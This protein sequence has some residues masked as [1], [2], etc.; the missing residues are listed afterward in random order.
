MGFDHVFDTNFTADLTIIEEGT[1]LILRLYK[2]LVQGDTSVALPQFTSCSPG[3]VKYCEHFYPEY[4]PNL[5]TAKSPQQM[6]GALIKTFYAEKMGVDPKPTSSAW[7]SCR[8]RP[9]SSSATARRCAP[10]ATRTWT[11]ASPPASWGRCSGRPVWT[12]PACP[13]RTS[14]TRSATA[15]G[16][17]LIFGA[18]G[19]VMESALR[20]VLELVTGKKV[21]TIY[22]HGD[23]MP[24]RGFEGVRY[25]ELKISEVG[26][27]PELLAHLVPDWDWLK[28]ATLK[29]AVAH[30]TANAHK[31]M[32]DI[33]AGGK[34]SECHFIEF[35]ACPGGCLGGG[36]QPIPTNKEIRAARAR[37]HLRRRPTDLD[38]RKSYENPAVLR[39]TRSSSP[40][41]RA[42]TRAT[43]CC[44]RTT[45]IGASSSNSAAKSRFHARATKKSPGKARGSLSSSVSPY[46]ATD[47][48]DLPT[49]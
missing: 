26:P 5:S 39:S 49:A 1:E 3:W 38:V 33:K 40:T 7:P 45:W 2:A 8:A 27:V 43:S 48:S 23:I 18:T 29:V 13:S 17:G 37:G 16:S 42:A 6:F 35:M 14:T 44:T 30:G 11:S 10:A 31:V 12:C 28:G 9:R 46:S 19:G 32:E 36:G 24:V 25:A 47:T 20:T 15:T 22:E 21:E 34:F 41:D 4:I